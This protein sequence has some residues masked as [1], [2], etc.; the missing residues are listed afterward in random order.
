LNNWPAGGIRAPRPL[1]LEADPAVLGAPF[2]LLERMS[3]QLTGS[4]FTPPRA[5]ALGLQLAEQLGRLHALPVADFAAM[6]PEPASPA[7]RVAELA[8][9]EHM[10]ASIGLRSSIIDCAIGW[11]GAHL[12]DAGDDVVLTHNDLGFHNFLT[13]GDELTALL[14]WELAAL[15]HPAADLGYI[16][17]FVGLMLPWNDFI[18][19]YEAAGGRHVDEVTLRFHTIWNAVRL[20]GLIMQARAAIA[21]GVV[22]DVEITFACADNTMLLLHAL[23]GELREAGAF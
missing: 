10:Q 6:V 12:G 3:G 22:N 18:Q 15:G 2:I 11:L 4:L 8:G 20:Y 9:F 1:L 7:A 17:P 19:R 21:A 5:A 16:K 23:A 14:D 13:D